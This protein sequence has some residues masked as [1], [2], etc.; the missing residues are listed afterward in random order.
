VILLLVSLCSGCVT[1]DAWTAKRDT[2]PVAPVRQVVAAWEKGV[3]FV[4][5]PTRGGAPNPGL[6]A[7][8]YLFGA[9]GAFP[10][11]GDGSLLVELYD[12]T[13]LT[14]GGQPR[15]KEKWNIDKDTLKRLLQKD[16]ICWGYSLFLPWGTYSRDIT[17]IHL[18]VKY[19]PKNGAPLFHP[20]PTMAVGHPDLV[21]M[22]HRPAEAGKAVKPV[23]E[24]QPTPELKIG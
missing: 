11:A 8:L 16:L 19:L 5:D 15:L 4:P 13:P 6:A 14:S 1:L 2:P 22:P 20:S 3:R 9:D 18:M 24:N 23:P 10:L 21:T 12:D 17:Q 7:R